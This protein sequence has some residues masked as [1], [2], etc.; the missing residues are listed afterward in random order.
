[1]GSQLRTTD[2]IDPSHHRMQPPFVNPVL[3]S[4]PAKP[5]PDKLPPPNNPMLPSGK[6][7]NGLP[8]GRLLS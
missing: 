3:N 8:G 5:Q 1:M 4:P 7:P 6:L 2:C